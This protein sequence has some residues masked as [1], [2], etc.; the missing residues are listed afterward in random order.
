VPP[1]AGTCDAITDGMT[2]TTQRFPLLIAI[3]DSEYSEI[4]LEHGLD[5]AGR[6]QAPDLHV[7]R[8]VEKPADLQAAKDALARAVLEGLDSFRVN[9][10]DWRTRLHVRCGKPVEEIA[11]LAS[12][13]QAE[14]LVI[15]RYGVHRRHGSLADGLVAAAPC[16]TLVVGFAGHEGA[17]PQCPWCVEVRA[18]SDGEQWFC[19]K[20]SA[21]DR[22]RLSALVPPTTS[23]GTGL[24]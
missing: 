18:R 7:V 15:G 6:H 21:P 2:L 13:I 22:L 23:S 16:P 1:R 10:P 4:V 5:Q 9:H 8:V 11:N 3:D 20:H 14:L 19:V 12:E 17:E 24:W